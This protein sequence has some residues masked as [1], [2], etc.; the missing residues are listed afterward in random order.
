MA[1]AS[2]FPKILAGFAAALALSCSLGSA[3]AQDFEPDHKLALYISDSDPAKMRSVLS[4][5]TNV[6]KH[7]NAIG[8]LVEIRIIAFNDG[9]HMLRLDTSP[10]LQRLHAF[11]TGVPNVAFVACG[12]T[13]DTM[14]RNEGARPEIFADAEMVQT[15]VAEIIALE[16]AGWTLVRP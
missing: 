6:S 9:L 2:I 5:A 15:G 10:V 13:L 1:I 14:E 12:N 16:E 4:V 11:E 8:E 3:T 7:Y